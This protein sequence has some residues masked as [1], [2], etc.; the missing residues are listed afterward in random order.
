MTAQMAQIAPQV[1]ER[2]VVSPRPR[3]QRGVAISGFQPS[4]DAP[5]QAR[6]FVWEVLREHGY[7]SLTEDA[8]LI[9]SELATNAVVHARS[10]FEV[11]VHFDA[12]TVT[13]SVSDSSPQRPVAGEPSPSDQAGRGL[14][15]VA[16]LAF[17]WGCVETRAGKT[18]WAELAR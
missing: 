5:R 8:V 9:A 14:A 2:T 7:C 15:V 3:M 11:A 10:R 13:L 18:V 1:H 16:A 17:D 6:R 4:P 12:G